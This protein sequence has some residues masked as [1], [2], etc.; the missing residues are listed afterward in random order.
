VLFQGGKERYCFDI[1]DK[2]QIAALLNEFYAY[3]EPEIENFQEAVEEFKDR[4]PELAKGLVAKL[5]DAHRSNKKFQA[6]FESFFTICQ[7]TLNP[8]ISRAAVEEMLVQHLLTERLIRKIFST[9]PNT[10]NR[11]F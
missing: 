3:T 4:V 5:D 10:E 1:T 11:A 6:A 7:R 8:N 9:I 2:K